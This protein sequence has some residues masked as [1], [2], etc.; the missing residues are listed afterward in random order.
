M[1]PLPSLTRWPDWMKWC[2]QTFGDQMK[3][4]FLCTHQIFIKVI[5]GSDHEGN[6]LT[7]HLSACLWTPSAHHLTGR[8][9]QWH[10]GLFAFKVQ[11]RLAQSFR[12]MWT[13]VYELVRTLDKGE[14]SLKQ[15]QV[16]KDLIPSCNC[17]ELPFMNRLGLTLALLNHQLTPTN[18]FKSRKCNFSSCY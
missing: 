4:R 12:N 17:L 13:G 15:M 2:K 5:P 6:I 11:E 18:Q 7:E 9:G 14:L 3:N 10:G 16:K 1:H 8:W